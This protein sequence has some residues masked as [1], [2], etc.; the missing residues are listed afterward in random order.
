MMRCWWLNAS[1]AHHL[2]FHFKLTINHEF[3]ITS[4]RSIQKYAEDISLFQPDCYYIDGYSKRCF[5]IFIHVYS[6]VCVC[7]YVFV[8][9]SNVFAFVWSE[10][11]K[12]PIQYKPGCMT[13]SAYG[14]FIHLYYIYIYN[15]FLSFLCY[16]SIF[17]IAQ[18][19]S[20]V[21]GVVAFV[22]IFTHSVSPDGICT[23]SPCFYALALINNVLINNNG[24]NRAICRSI[25]ARFNSYILSF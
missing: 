8:W 7:V 9:F 18:F 11:G 15:I 14:I 10:N 6:C 17:F 3:Q 13:K 16:Y 5:F 25:R 21:V 23:L 2:V 24:P 22:A 12:T 19:V 1:W 20:F 4:F